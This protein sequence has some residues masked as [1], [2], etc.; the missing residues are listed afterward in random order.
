MW[1]PAAEG[2]KSVDALIK[3]VQR[4]I[5][6]AAEEAGRKRLEQTLRTLQAAR[7]QLIEI[8]ADGREFYLLA[9]D[10]RPAP[11]GAAGAGAG[12]KTSPPAA[13]K[14]V[15]AGPLSQV[16]FQWN[17]SHRSWAASIPLSAGESFIL[18]LFRPHGCRTRQPPIELVVVVAPTFDWLMEHAAELRRRLAETLHP[19]WIQ[20][21]RIEGRPIV[22][23]D[24]LER[25]LRL[26]KAVWESNRLFVDYHA[27]DIFADHLV[28][29]AID[30]TGAFLRPPVVID[31]RL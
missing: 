13:S 1:F 31:E 5:T 15:L 28:R 16:S 23:V 30:A 21:W 29:T 14:E 4:L 10:L 9:K 18:R 26:H 3:Q 27:G 6:D 24:K 11:K 2:I 12:A 7:S 19:T 17:S 8:R 25:E 22:T 20:E